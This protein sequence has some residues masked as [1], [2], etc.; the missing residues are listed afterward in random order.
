MIDLSNPSGLRMTEESCTPPEDPSTPQSKMGKTL[1]AD[2]EHVIQ[3]I[4]EQLDAQKVVVE[5]GAIRVRKIVHDETNTVDLGLVSEE[6][7]VTRVPVGK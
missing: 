3:I 2:R 7:T 6:V 1:E 5:T 4:E